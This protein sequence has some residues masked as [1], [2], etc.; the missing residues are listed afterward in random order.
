MND[1]IF[2][3]TRFDESETI[4]DGNHWQVLDS[5]EEWM[6]FSRKDTNDDN[7]W[8]SHIAIEGMHCAA[9]GI[10]IENILTSVNGVIS[11]SVNSASGRAQ[12]VWSNERTKPS[13]WLSSITKAGYK[14]IPATEFHNQDLRKKIQRKALWRMLVA[15]FCMMQVMMYSYPMYIANPGDMTQ[16]NLNL[17]RWASWLL[18]LPVILFSCSPFFQN[19]MN[20]LKRFEIGMDT[21]V[22]LGILITFLI[23]T[24]VTFDPTSLLGHEVYFDSLTMFVFFLLT[25][26]FIEL[27]MRDRTAGALDVLMRRIPPAV[28]RIKPDGTY[29]RIALNRVAINNILSIM[30]GESFPVDGI[31]T[32]GSTYADEAL[33]TGE[34]RPIMK[35][36]GDAVIAG[37]YNL[38]STVQIKASAVGKSTRYA[39]IVELMERASVE[40]PR[41]A[42]LADRIARPFLFVV[43]LASVST[44][45]I[46]WPLDHSHALM[47]AVAVLIVT[48]P[49]ALSLATP[50]AMLTMSGALARSGILV[51]RIQALETLTQIDTIVFDKTGTLTF[52]KMRVGK[53]HTANDYTQAEAILIAASIAK[54]S[55]HPASK[56]LVEALNRIH[57]F[58]SKYQI[59]N[60]LEIAGSGLTA[61]S[62]Y[63]NLKL[64]SAKFCDLENNEFAQFANKGL[65][66]HL[67]LDDTWIA[68]FEIIEMVKSEAITAVQNLKD[69]GIH[70]QVLSGDHIDSVK[71]IAMI[72]GINWF[73]GDCS[74]QD[75]LSLIQKL[76]SAGHSVAMVGD[77]L[78]DGPVLAGAN[79]SI[80]MGQSVPIAQ[81]QSDFV[82][83]SGK[84][85]M[86]PHLII[87]AKKTMHIVKQN[88]I[89]AAIYN[90][91]CVPIAVM[92][93]MPA[94]LAGLGMAMSSLFVILNA[95][96]LSKSPL[97]LSK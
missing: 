79:V 78:N 34:S 25:G 1:I 42:L 54:H 81:A 41:L 17:L 88:L 2:N 76:Q 48:C 51:R 11:A 55:L 19:A 73:R 85:E 52:D 39:Q 74:P 43:L 5:H 77:G 60:V 75:K 44:A 24:A 46:L 97:N 18:S 70:V 31:I 95:A 65:M 53:I 36:T 90:A 49:C 45:A 71:T 83:M 33:L 82:V 26:R 9:C 3:K 15:G 68:S 28:L 86:V 23:S 40:K 20:D 16:D 61:E 27:R 14:V 89:W 6:T 47:A 66:V 62:N 67:V 10:S 63:G 21:P 92:G 30:P 93:L 80:A 72:C 13:E 8:E 58:N 38:T 57:T 7:Q 22:S 87:Q 50:A 84:L 69:I 37:S 64:G 59:N 56:A 32:S 12:V 29:E 4:P 91:I 96:R 35:G 94:W